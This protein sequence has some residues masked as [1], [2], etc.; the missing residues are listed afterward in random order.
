[1]VQKRRGGKE[2]GG[3]DKR[4]NVK[5]YCI[6]KK[7]RISTKLRYFF[8]YSENGV[9]ICLIDGGERRELVWE[10]AGE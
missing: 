8:D 7:F 5:P 3:K 10:Q 4:A 9:L 6:A 2:N 1:M